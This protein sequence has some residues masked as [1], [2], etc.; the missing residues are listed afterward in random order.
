MPI[1][2][3]HRRR[4]GARLQALPLLLG[5][6]CPAPSWSAATGGHPGRLLA[7]NEN[8]GTLSIID[9]QRGGVLAK[10][11]EGGFAGHEAAVSPDGRFAFVP[12]YGD[13]NAGTPGTDGRDIVKIDLATRQVVG[14]YTFDHGVRPHAALFNPHDGLLYVTTELDRTVSI[15]APR[16]MTLVGAIPTGQPLSHMLAISRDGR[17]LYVS[18]IE[19]GSVSVLDLKTRQL[20][21]VTPVSAKAQR[22]AISIDDRMIFTADQTQPR[23]AVMDTATRQVTHWIALSAPGMGMT[24]TP[25]GRWLLVAIESASQVAVVDLKALRVFRTIDLPKYPHEITMRPDGKI[26]Y[27]SCSVTGE[28]ASLRTADWKVVR[29]VQSGAFVD[30]LAWAPAAP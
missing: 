14:R 28:V 24:A 4:V 29:R 25:D 22:I 18:N 13:G 1:V 7:V 21:G 3:H 11:P 6:L 16:T 5:L 2:R 27:V 12:V 26:A 19:P 10:V 9:P 8:E 15:I 17:F 30:G 20:L 23:V